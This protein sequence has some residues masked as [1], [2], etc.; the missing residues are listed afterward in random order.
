MCIC[1]QVFVCVCV[2]FLSRYECVVCKHACVCVRVKIHKYIVIF[3]FFFALPNS[4]SRKTISTSSRMFLGWKNSL[5]H[6]RRCRIR[7]EQSIS[8]ATKGEAMKRRVVRH[9]GVFSYSSLRYFI[10]TL[11]CTSKI[12]NCVGNVHH[13]FTISVESNLSLVFLYWLVT[14]SFFVN[15]ILLKH[16]KASE[17]Y[18]FVFYMCIPVHNLIRY[19]TSG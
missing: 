8:K 2:L 3:F 16:M 15:I 1:V 10:D 9:T 6:A 13:V 5:I 17:N 12:G 14:C 19:Y 7:V 4:T 18:A 11:I